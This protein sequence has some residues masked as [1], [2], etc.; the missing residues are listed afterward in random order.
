MQPNFLYDSK[1]FAQLNHP[2]FKQHV[3]EPVVLAGGAINSEPN[4]FSAQNPIF[5]TSNS[6]S[7]LTEK[8]ESDIPLPPRDVRLEGNETKQ[9]K[10]QY[11]NF[12]RSLSIYQNNCCNITIINNK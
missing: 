7:H 11:C 8:K 10:N 12:I 3:Y 9:G 2:N 6:L 5:H 4:V 1:T